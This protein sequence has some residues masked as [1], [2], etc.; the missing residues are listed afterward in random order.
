APPHRGRRSGRAHAG[1]GPARRRLARL[2]PARPRPRRHRSRGGAR[3]RL[4]PLR[5]RQLAQ[6]DRKST[7]LNSSHVKISYAVFR[8]KK[9][10]KQHPDANQPRTAETTPTPLNA[11]YPLHTTT[12][13]LY[14]AVDAAEQPHIETHLS[15]PRQ[16]T[17]IT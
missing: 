2:R 1:C 16:A 3:G 9:K 14:Q 17:N 5:Q 4:L 10:N 15:A 7:R 6:G 8:L 12:Q 13:R 11:L